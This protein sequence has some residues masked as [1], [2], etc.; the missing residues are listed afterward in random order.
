MTMGKKFFLLAFAASFAFLCFS[1]NASADY[2]KTKIAV[3][4]FQQQGGRADSDM[5]KIVA[6]W[7]VT[8]LVKEGRFA[9][10]ERRLLNKVLEE[11]KIGVSG[12]VDAD[13]AS[14]LGKVLGAK[15][16]I[17]GSV[18]QYQNIIEVNARIIDVESSSI[19]A[20][21]SAKSTSTVALEDLVVEMT[22]KI[23]RDFPLEGYVVLRD[24]NSVL[25][26]LGRQSGV[27]R[28]MRFQAFKEGKVI[29]HPKTGEVLDVETIDIGEIE[30]TDVSQKT[31]SGTVKKETSS[32][33]IGYGVMVRSAL[34]GQQQAVE[35]EQRP[36]EPEKKE[37][38]RRERP[39]KKPEKSERKVNIPPP[40]F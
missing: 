20:A 29:K 8:A 17:T 22:D 25:I 6:E 24:K 28:G 35:E 7:L 27:K 33:A 37:P 38:P 11:Q 26:D 9:V 40:T 15:V 30:V 39:E 32:G 12:I 1:Q 36:P 14:K 18:L 3:L 21:E 19:M 13:S 10:I 5:G 31:S 23:I 34:Q 4:D 2:K 16:V